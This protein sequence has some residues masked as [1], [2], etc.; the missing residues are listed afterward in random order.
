MLI[1]A[2][3]KDLKIQKQSP[4]GVL[5][6]DCSLKFHKTLVSFLTTFGGYFWKYAEHDTQ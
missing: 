5:L 1:S 4:A 6:L 3:W 2:N